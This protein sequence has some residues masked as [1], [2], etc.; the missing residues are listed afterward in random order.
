VG[1]ALDVLWR[2]LPVMIVMSAGIVD[3]EKRSAPI[4]L[5]GLAP[6]LVVNSTRMD[7][8]IAGG[9]GTGGD[10][11]QILHPVPVLLHA[12]ALSFAMKRL[13]GLVW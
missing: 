9:G 6:V 7:N 12:F 3:H 2:F 4:L 11:L 10:W 5:M 1:V 8:I 13:A